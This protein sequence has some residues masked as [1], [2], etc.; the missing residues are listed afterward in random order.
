MESCLKDILN[1]LKPL[2]TDRAQRLNV[3]DELSSILRSQISLKDALVKPFGSFVSNLYSKWGDL[4]ISV[5][6]PN[7]ATRQ[8]Q[9]DFLWAIMSALRRAG[10]A[11]NCNVIENARVPVLKF[12]SNY[13]DISCDISINNHI[14]QIKSK[15]LLWIS[16]IDERFHDM[17]LLV[18]EW[19][20]AQDINN[21]KEGTLN[22]YSLCLMVIFHFQTCTPPIFPPLK[23][24]YEGNVA[25][26]ITGTT[27][28]TER[29]I[30]D[31][32]LANIAR[33]K[34]QVY[35]QKNK[36]SLSQLLI[37]FFQKFSN[38]G[39]ISSTNAFC[40]YT[41]RMGTRYLIKTRALS[42]EDPFEQTENTARAVGWAELNIISRA[43]REACRLFSSRNVCS[44]R[45]SLLTYLVR[46]NIRSQLR[47]GI[48]II[49]DDDNDDDDDDDYETMESRF[50]DTFTISHASNTGSS[51]NIGRVLLLGLAGAAAAGAVAAGAVAAAA[52]AAAAAEQQQHSS[53]GSSSSSSGGSSSGGSGGG[54]GGSGSG[55]SGSR[56]FFND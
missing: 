2:E 7:S 21:P 46:P 24:I 28:F 6:F 9:Q 27:A 40:T 43:F 56:V 8:R 42:I 16:D 49:D 5:D 29:L 54:G 32:C 12:Q 1:L 33:F 38:I 10:F 3:I 34:S 52:A 26:A 15:M 45:T 35:R 50:R 20:K 13:R 14:G 39:S 55:S 19:A 23:E 25:D 51:R 31:E 47:G 36:S 22:S 53:S 41:G 30:R 11:R 17:V 44:D 18:K 48:H 37:E 4:D